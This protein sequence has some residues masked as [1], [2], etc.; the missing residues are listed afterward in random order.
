MFQ[1]LRYG[2]RMLLKQPGFTAVAVLSLALGIGANTA[3]FSVADE[4][5]LKTLPVRSPEQLVLFSWTSGPRLMG[6]GFWPGVFVDPKTGASTSQSFSYLTFQQFQTES[7]SLS[8]VF[9]FSGMFRMNGLDQDLDSPSGQL[10]SGNYHTALG[11]P[12]V[13]G[14]T[15][16]VDDDDETASPVAVISH[17]YWDRAFGLDPATV[18][19]TINLGKTVFTIVGITPAGFSGTQDL[20]ASPDFSIPLG[21]ANRI[22]D[23]G[24]KFADTMKNQPWL[25]PLMVMGRLKPGAGFNQ[26]RVEL[27]GAFRATALEGFNSNPR[28]TPAADPPDTPQLGVD[29]GGKGLTESRR[30]LSKAVTIMMVIV[31]LVLLIVCSNLANLLLARAAT[32]RKEI[33]VRQALGASRLRVIRQ[34]LTESLVLAICGAALGVLFAVW[35]KDLFLVWIN[36]VTP[37]FVIQPRLDLRVLG[38]TA[39]VTV[40]TGI[41]IGLAPALRATRVDLNQVMKD[42]SRG[43]SASRSFVSRALLVTQVA[44]S[45]VLLVSAGLFVRTL[46]NLQRA[47]LGFN[48]KNLLLFDVHPQWNK[49]KRPQLADL[50]ERV[51]ERLRAVPGVR[52]AT[53]SRVP[54]LERSMGDAVIVVP[55]RIR[56]PGEDPSVYVQFVWHNFFET[57]EMPLVMGRSF[58]PRD[59][60]GRPYLAVVNETLARKYFH[61]VD[62]I[63]H[64]FAVTKDVRAQEVA[65][66][67]SVEIVGVVR[68]AKYTRAREGALPAVFF[69]FSPD[70]ATF[71]VRTSIDPAPLIAS[72]QEGVREV[73]A[74][75]R[76]LNFRTQTEQV[77]LTFA[78]ERHFAFLSSLFGVVA[79]LLACVGLYGLLSYGV[80]NRTQEIGIRMALGADR[81]HVVRLV[82]RETLVLVLMGVGIGLVGA[83]AVTQMIASM[84]YGVAP[85]DSVAILVAISLMILVSAAAACL[86]ARKASRVDPMVALRYE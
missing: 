11:V 39:A 82:M 58:G 78:R 35:G 48:T 41:V 51:I 25:W 47:D 76:L 45:V 83:F 2:A 72:I 50:Y 59:R 31:S 17:R 44:M 21:M 6:D 64:H 81:W 32:R 52:S 38:F 20:G 24:P 34:L 75:L 73:D 68:D 19:K 42:S 29:A 57:M 8:D 55:G 14:R 5:L 3:L 30:A 74:D 66:S 80:A 28:F 15:L 60:F 1:D 85:N 16:T 70:P 22:S 56:E 43:S 65:A 4:V 71:E 12:A 26:V 86:P 36:R 40:L 37:S 10:V 63:G 46:L 27:E 69:P 79:L 7:A 13:L 33:A 9:A 23:I 18:G 84:L 61:D 77:K 53:T 62:P 54:L 67:E 49:H